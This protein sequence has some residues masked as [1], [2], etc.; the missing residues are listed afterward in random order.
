MSRFAEVTHAEWIGAPVA[1][2]RRQFADL[3]HHIAADVHPKLALR[4][5][6]PRDGRTRFEQRVRL[7][8]LTQ[9]DVF[10]RRFAPDGTMTDE[11]VEGFNKGGSLVFRFTPEPRG[12]R[13][14]TVVEVTIRLPLPPLLGTLLRPLLEAQ[15]RRELM[16]AVAEDRHDLEVRGYPPRADRTA[17]PGA[18]DVHA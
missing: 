11:S 17:A 2:V 12:G 6:D 1:T 4:V 14:G 18:A 8:G 10:E 9:R 3:Q 15:V 13:E 7:L 5:L 16:A